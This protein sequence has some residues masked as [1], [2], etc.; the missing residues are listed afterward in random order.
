M[1]CEFRLLCY[2]VRYTTTRNQSDQDVLSGSGAYDDTPIIANV[3]R[4]ASAYSHPEFLPG[5]VGC[6]WCPA[7]KHA[8]LQMAAYQYLSVW[9]LSRVQGT[10]RSISR[11]DEVSSEVFMYFV[12]LFHRELDGS[13]DGVVRAICNTR[14]IA[15]SQRNSRDDDR[16]PGW[17]EAVPFRF[18]NWCLP[19]LT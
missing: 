18:D 13:C 17:H 4:A 7:L 10:K 19:K 9:E 6:E 14:R 2:T 12:G 16:N 1:T 11:I 8:G 3:D 15:G 5:P